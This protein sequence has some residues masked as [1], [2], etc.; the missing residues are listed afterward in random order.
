MHQSKRGSPKPQ[1]NTDLLFDAGS[2][3]DLPHSSLDQSVQMVAGVGGCE[4]PDYNKSVWLGEISNERNKMFTKKKHVVQMSQTARVYY[5]MRNQD[6]RQ[7]KTEARFRPYGVSQLPKIVKNIHKP[8]MD[9]P[10][11]TTT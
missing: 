7:V 6:Q 9:L 2:N 11:P 10:V 8:L 3:A 1:S 4:T 5:N